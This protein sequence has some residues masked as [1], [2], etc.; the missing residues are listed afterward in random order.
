MIAAVSIS[1]V[2]ILAYRMGF[3]SKVLLGPIDLSCNVLFTQQLDGVKVG[4]SVSSP[5]EC[6]RWK[7]TGL[8]FFVVVGFFSSMDLVC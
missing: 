8:C 3:P 4:G 1:S 6:L 7:S 5:W 2:N